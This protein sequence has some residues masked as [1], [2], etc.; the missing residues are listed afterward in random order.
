MNTTN[1]FTPSLTNYTRLGPILVSQLDHALITPNSCLPWPGSENVVTGFT[2]SFLIC[3]KMADQ[4]TSEGSPERK[5]TTENAQSSEKVE[6][7]VFGPD[8]SEL[9]DLLD[10]TFLRF[11]PR[12]SKWADKAVKFQSAACAVQWSA[13]T[14]LSLIIRHASYHSSWHGHSGWQ[15]WSK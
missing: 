1:D 2:A 8:D 14:P 5:Q 10:S 3:V 15:H 11:I 9:D 12:L 13:M 7:K 6:E 4:N